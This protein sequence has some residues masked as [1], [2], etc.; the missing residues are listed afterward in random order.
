MNLVIYLPMYCDKCGNQLKN[1]NVKFCDNCGAEIL[2]NKNKT[3]T[4]TTAGTEI[5]CPHCGQS[6]LMGL[7]NCAKCGY[8][9]ED[10]KVAVIL[11]YI[12]SLIFGIFGIIPGIYLLTRNN[13]KSK[14]QGLV[15]IIM[16]VISA[17]GLLIFWPAYLLIIPIVIGG[18][19]LWVNNYCI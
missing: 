19:F 3:N 5:I 13:G 16:S 7:Q 8:L 2:A 4:G 18:I 17:L 9:L 6:T 15:I 10:N 12:I 14:T 1:E 11:G